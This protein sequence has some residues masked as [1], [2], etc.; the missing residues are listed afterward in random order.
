MSNSETVVVRLVAEVGQ[1]K[2]AMTQAAASTARVGAVSK[3]TAAATAASARTSTAAT[4]GQVVASE[5]AAAAS[6]AATKQQ[7][8]GATAATAGVKKQT[9]ALRGM[10]PLIASLGLAMFAKSSVDSFKNATVEVMKLKRVTGDTPEAVSRLRYALK[11]SGVDVS[12]F[13]LRAGM[14]D[15]KLIE[16]SKTTK[17]TAEMT[18]LLGTNFLDANGKVRPLTEMLPDISETFKKLGPGARSTALALQL[19]GRSGQAMLPFLL[20]GRKGVQDLMGATKESSIIT[21]AQIDKQVEA[22]KAQRELSQSVEDLKMSLGQALVPVLTDLTKALVPVLDWFTRLNPAIKNTAVYVLGAALAWKLLSP[23]ITGVGGGLKQVIGWFAGSNVAVASNTAMLEAN[24]AAQMGNNA[25]KL[26]GGAAGAAAGAGGLASEAGAGAGLA[27]AGAGAGMA[28][29]AATATTAAAGLAAYA[30]ASYASYAG[31]KKLAEGGHTAQ[32]SILAL[33]TAIPSA[34]VSLTGLAEG[35][36]NANFAGRMTADSMATMEVRLSAM[37]GGAGGPARVAREMALLKDQMDPRDFQQL[38]N[39]TPLLAGAL[40]KA[41]YE[42]NKTSGAIQKIPTHKQVVIA[43]KFDQINNGLKYSEQRLSSLRQRNQPKINAEIAPLVSRLGAAQRTVER[44]KQKKK[45]DVD[46][47]NRASARVTRIQ[48]D[49]DGVE[50]RNKPSL[51]VNNQPAKDSIRSVWDGLSSL[52]S[53]GWEAVV[54]VVKGSAA[55]GP[56]SGPGTGTSDSIPARLSHGEYVINARSTRKYAGLVHAINNDAVPGYAS[57]GKVVAYSGKQA[58]RIKRHFTS[59][60]AYANLGA[61]GQQAKDR[62]SSYFDAVNARQSVINTTGR[63]LRNGVQFD[64]TAEASARENVASATQAQTDA[65]AALYTA[66]KKLNEASRA[67]RPQ[68]L[69]DLAAAQKTYADSTRDLAS[70][71]TAQA[72]AAPTVANIRAQFAAKVAKTRQFANDLMALKRKGMPGE[73][74]QDIISMGVDGGSEMAHVLIGSTLADMKAFISGQG[75]LAGST[76]TIGTLEADLENTQGT[77]AK[78]RVALKKAKL[79]HVVKKRASGG[80]VTR[81]HHYLTGE[82]GPELIKSPV[83]GTIIPAAQTARMLD[84]GDRSFSQP[85][86]LRLDSGVVW[87]GLVELNR[88]TGFTLRSLDGARR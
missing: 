53:H 43:G 52:V 86:Q 56:I 70:A 18:K 37:A 24:T 16:A 79:T 76:T 82:W 26:G 40:K 84:G 28:G 75:D 64:F 71:Q 12:S 67:D 80:P 17:T 20:K 87:N 68:A 32:A 3:E 65:E 51:D 59:Y 88:K 15:R 33:V 27:G 22:L 57:G 58:R 83:S 13:T 47:I 6:T 11:M 63:G 42:I 69:A 41:G 74:L 35:Y 23:L 36:N 66:R 25:A 38:I 46:A 60:A 39:S 31:S 78:K 30:A 2:A 7:V 55:G 21:Q 8:A 49:I 72:A 85:V 62:A 45:P 1:Y 77:I 61:Y 44:L 54:N 34:G 19:F 14:L 5:Q 48:Q 9:S 10:I 50:Q 81:G 29:V 4:R 73:I